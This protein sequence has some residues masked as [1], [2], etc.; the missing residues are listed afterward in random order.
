MPWI[1]VANWVQDM[2]AL[3]A[4]G[5]RAEGGH[6]NFV[7]V[8]V[9]VVV[10]FQLNLAYAGPPTAGPGPIEAVAPRRRWARRCVINRSWC[11]DPE[12]VVKA[13]LI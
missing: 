5:Q 8:T 11:R 3:A 7:L 4:G 12:I 10:V 1:V 9:G 2:A 13:V 6:S